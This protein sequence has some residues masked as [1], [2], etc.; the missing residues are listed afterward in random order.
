M[1]FHARAIILTIVSLSTALTGC[2]TLDQRV[3]SAYTPVAAAR[4]GGPLALTATGAP[5]QTYK[6]RPVLWIIGTV[7]NSDGEKMGNLTSQRSG[8]EILRDAL[9]Q[10]LTA[11]GYTVG[12]DTGRLEA[13]TRAVNVTRVQISLDE[14][15]SLVKAEGSCTVSVS[16]E[17]WSK[18][19]VA[20]KL[21][22]ESRF[23]DFA[24]R[25]REMLMQT[26]LRTA[27]QNLMTRALPEI[28]AVL[29]GS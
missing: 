22:Y 27:L 24:I 19:A 3:S 7:K 23:S 13:A 28:V 12:Q 10:E 6:E 2:A 17:L 20:K 11:A 9:E 29:G 5:S 25:N 14:K 18:G 4:G 15:Q 1:S 21:E 16:L 8:E 26:V